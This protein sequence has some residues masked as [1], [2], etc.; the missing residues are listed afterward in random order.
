M[1]T[2]Q[3]IEVLKTYPPDAQVVAYWEGGWSTLQKHR[4]TKDEK[5]RAV[6][7]FDVDEHGSYDYDMR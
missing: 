3:L 2:T 6:V 5:D 1:T 4:L 7:E